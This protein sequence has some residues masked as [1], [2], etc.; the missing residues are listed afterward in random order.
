MVGGPSAKLCKRWGRLSKVLM[1]EGVMSKHGCAANSCMGYRI[2]SDCRNHSP[3]QL[4]TALSQLL[5]GGVLPSAPA[6]AVNLT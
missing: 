3:A 5:N 2:A 6:S 1:V 4:A